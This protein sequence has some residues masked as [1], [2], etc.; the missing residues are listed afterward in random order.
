MSARY[1]VTTM[2]PLFDKGWKV[3]FFLSWKILQLKRKQALDSLKSDWLI[4]VDEHPTAAYGYDDDNWWIAEA[5][6]LVD[7]ACIIP[8]EFSRISIC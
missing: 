4:A 2:Q 5:S 8:V 6:T 7:C 3:Y 1:Q